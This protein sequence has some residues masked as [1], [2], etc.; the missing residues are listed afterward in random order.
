MKF[1][2]TCKLFLFI[3]G[4]C[5]I[6]NKQLDDSGKLI[7][8]SV[9]RCGDLFAVHDKCITKDDKEYSIKEL[10]HVS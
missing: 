10:N 8:K 7:I 3:S 6:C 9:G 1:Y 5:A 2:F 4:K